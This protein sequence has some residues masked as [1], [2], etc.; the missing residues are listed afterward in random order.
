LILILLEKILESN[1][2]LPEKIAFRLIDNFTT[3]ISKNANP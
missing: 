3:V 1:Y 2:P